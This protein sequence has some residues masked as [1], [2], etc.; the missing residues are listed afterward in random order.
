M[1]PA[2]SRPAL[3]T[4]KRLQI[5]T[6][7]AVHDSHCGFHLLLYDSRVLASPVTTCFLRTSAH[8]NSHLLNSS[9]LRV[10]ARRARKLAEQVPPSPILSRKDRPNNQ[11]GHKKTQKTGN[12]VHFGPI[13]ANV[14]NLISHL[15]G[16]P[17]LGV[18]VAYVWD[19][20]SLMS[21]ARRAPPAGVLEDLWGLTK[22]CVVTGCLS[23]ND[24]LRYLNDWSV[25]QQR[26]PSW[27]AFDQSTMRMLIDITLPCAIK[28][29]SNEKLE[30][31][32]KVVREIAERIEEPQFTGRA[33]SSN[34]PLSH[35]LEVRVMMQRIF[36]LAVVE[37]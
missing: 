36:A 28:R 30:K 23:E 37:V 21:R 14:Q 20:A 3:H 8:E 5:G 18:L 33:H 11:D 10:A 25:L 9:C 6:Q 15:Q 24:I 35:S 2:V 13:Q 31:L 1:G 19:Q 22:E 27:F 17:P 32:I 16:K 7:H 34:M 12:S 4:F 26:W 29:M